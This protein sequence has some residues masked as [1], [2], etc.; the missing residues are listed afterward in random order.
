VNDRNLKNGKKF[1]KKDPRIN[2][3]GRPPLFV[4]TVISQLE[5]QGIENVKPSQIV[6]LYEKMMNCTIAKLNELA[7]DENAGWEIRQTAKY[8]LKYPEKAWN[9]IKDRAHGKAKQTGE[10]KLEGQIDI[11]QIVGIDIIP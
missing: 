3:K 6:D 2:R 8:M 11:T 1:K 4:S 9:E 10:M 5:K 7:T